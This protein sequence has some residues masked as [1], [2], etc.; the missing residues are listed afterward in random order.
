M[1][2]FVGTYRFE[3]NSYGCHYLLVFEL[4]WIS[5]VDNFRHVLNLGKKKVNML[6]PRPQ[7]LAGSP[8]FGRWKLATRNFP[9]GTESLANADHVAT[10]KISSPV[11][12][13]LTSKNEVREHVR[14]NYG[15]PIPNVSKM[16]QIWSTIWGKEFRFFKIRF[17]GKRIQMSLIDKNEYG[18]VPDH[19][20]V[21]LDSKRCRRHFTQ[22]AT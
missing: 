10:V 17:H 7:I 1:K 22:H 4:V 18:C 19:S 13:S 5:T 6:L 21:L 9:H 2:S 20:N 12:V 16:P 3:V 14:I 8:H 11:W 15:L